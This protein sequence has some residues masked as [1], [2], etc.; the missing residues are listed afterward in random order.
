MSVLRPGSNR[1]L[2]LNKGQGALPQ[3]K[4]WYEITIAQFVEQELTELVACKRN[5]N[6][7]Y[8]KDKQCCSAG[9]GMEYR[10]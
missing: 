7:T 4:G 10:K 2:V 3:Y 8:Y 9:S 1:H 6:S 5:I